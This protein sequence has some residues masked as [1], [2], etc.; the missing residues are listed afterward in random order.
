MAVLS[1]LKG[2]NRKPE[3]TSKRVVKITTFRCCATFK[4]LSEQWPE[5]RTFGREVD[6]KDPI[7]YCG[8]VKN[9]TVSVE[10]ELYRKARV[11]A[12]QRETS[13]SGLVRNHLQELVKEAEMGPEQQKREHLAAVFDKLA[14]GTRKHPPLGKLKR[15]EIYADRLK[16]R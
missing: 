12:A 16:L 2:A 1:Q 7:A 13:L 9:I 6:G 3:A 5:V 4:C 14:N 10:D 8:S 15:D 11:V